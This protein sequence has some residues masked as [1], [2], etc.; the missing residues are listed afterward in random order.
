M[1]TF[2]CC[3]ILVALIG[4]ER[5]SIG[6]ISYGPM[7]RQQVTII[8]GFGAADTA[9]VGS[10]G[11]R[12]AG[13]YNFE[14]FDSIKIN[15]SARRLVVRPAFDHIL[16]KV[17]PGYYVIDSLSAQQKDFS[18]SIKPVELAKPQ[19]A[20]ITFVVQ[21]TESSLL[22]SQFRVVGWTAY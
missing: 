1:R 2:L 6:P 18:F 5:T 17:G 16:I 10:Q 9:T 4:C 12:I 11:I 20:A 8:D 21:E 14:P 22:L 13:Y 7:V 15:F 19:Y 3:C